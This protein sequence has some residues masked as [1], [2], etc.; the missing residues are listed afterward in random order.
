MLQKLY[1]KNYAIIEELTIVFDEHL[2]IITGETGAGKSIILGALSLILGERVDT[3]VL[4]NRNEKSIVEATFYTKDNKALNKFLE[5]EG[6]DIEEVTIIRREISASGKSRAFVNDTPVTLQYLNLITSQLVDLHRQF[7]NLAIHNEGF[8]YKVVDA[9]AQSG[10]I[11]NEYLGK[12]KAWKD[13]KTK[14]ERLKSS[15]HQLHQEADYKQ[16]LY[17]ELDQFGLTINKIEDAEEKL[18]QLN[19]ADYIIASLKMVYFSLEES[20]YA[21]NQELKKLLQ[22]LGTV[23][24]SY[25]EAQILYDRI[26][27][28]LIELKDIG[29]EADDLQHKINID[30]EELIHL[31]EINDVGYRL[32]KKHNVHSTE[33]LIEIYEK[34]QQELK[35]TCNATDEIEALELEVGQLYDSVKTIADELYNY[36]LKALQAFAQS[37]NTNLA[38][39]GM[40]SADFK[41]EL[42]QKDSFDEFGNTNIGFLIDTN[43]SGKYTPIQKTASGGEL[44]RIMLSIKTITASALQ[45]PTMIFD[46]VDTGI[47]GEAALQV[48]IMMQQLGMSQQII[49]ITHQPQVAAKGNKHFFIYKQEKD[50]QIKTAVHTLNQEEKIKAIAQMIGGKQPSEAAINNAKELIEM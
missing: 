38:L 36:R 2:N 21:V 4:I 16:F 24:K 34:L 6:L 37:V 12:Y 3:S 8:M 32:L 14:L 35:Q 50:G 23:T 19:N 17:D 15:I 46:E 30:P 9:I 25:P 45:L 28:T 22:Q 47:S 29:M 26:N 1:I 27:S 49:C 33:Q 20:E 39:I 7:D 40:P 5:H 42:I 11:Y 48:G 44:S 10:L 18:K 41:I 31:Q 43:K 13:A